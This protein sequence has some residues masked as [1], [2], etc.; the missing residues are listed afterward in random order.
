MSSDR[1]ESEMISYMKEA[2]GSW[3]AVEHESQVS[4]N[5]SS[6]FSLSGIPALIV[7]KKN[8]GGS[9][10]MVT[11]D[12]RSAVQSHAG[13]EPEKVIKHILKN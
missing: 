9:W 5:L 11:K 8:E 12:G 1:S 4:D 10:S 2:H 6:H 7:M 13:C 3:L